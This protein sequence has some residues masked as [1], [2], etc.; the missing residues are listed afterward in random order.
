MKELAIK[1]QC[2]KGNKPN[3]LG[4]VSPFLN[5][6][7]LLLPDC[8]KNQIDTYQ[9]KTTLK[10]AEKMV[11][12]LPLTAEE[13]LSILNIE[14][15]NEFPPEKFQIVLD[16]IDD[17]FKY[18]GYPKKNKYPLRVFYGF[19]KLTKKIVKKP[20]VIILYENGC[21]RLN[22]RYVNRAMKVI[23]QRL[24]TD[25]ETKDA[26]YCNRLF[27]KNEYF[28][29]EKIWKG[30]IEAILHH[31]FLADKNNV[32]KDEREHIKELLKKE[33]FDFYGDKVSRFF[34]SSFTF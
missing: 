16:T 8:Q 5:T 3:Y 6:E 12:G 26:K 32:P 27:S 4:F 11:E 15:L 7:G 31:N 14:G 33:V 30:N 25:E 1:T 9:A 20:S 10:Q 13:Y 17:F 28:I 22:D 29:N 18:C 23:Y 34:Q 24:Q 2:K 21:S 19:K